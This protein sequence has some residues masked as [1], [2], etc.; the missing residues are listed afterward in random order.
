MEEEYFIDIPGYEG[1]YQA[2][3]LGRVRSVR[4]TQIY[5]G[6]RI[7]MEGK[8]LKPRVNK[9]GYGRLV[10]YKN[11]ESHDI[12]V[13]QLV[14][15]AFLGHIRC[16][17]DIVPDHID[18]DKMNNRIENIRLVSGRSNSSTCFR[19]DRHRKSSIYTGVSWNKKNKNWNAYIHNEKKISLGSFSSE[20]DAHNAYK[21]ALVKLL[22][23]GGEL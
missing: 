12:G 11:K 17:Q 9:K 6:R 14:A 19:K 22:K 20:I 3:N 8:M 4:R 16:G 21:S 5:N 18:G 2:S 23:E 7:T 13:H 10:L 15:M 1:I